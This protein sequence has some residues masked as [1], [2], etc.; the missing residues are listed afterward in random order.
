MT[1]KAFEPLAT[2]LPDAS[3]TFTKTIA[4]YGRFD[5]GSAPAMMTSLSMRHAAT[6][7]GQRLVVMRSSLSGNRTV[8]SIVSTPRTLSP[9]HVDA[10]IDIGRSDAAIP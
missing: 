4:S 7:S 9:R 6:R 8:V 1:Q 2:D 5:H 10:T 3:E